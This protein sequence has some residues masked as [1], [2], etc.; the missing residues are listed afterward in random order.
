MISLKLSLVFLNI[1]GLEQRNSYSSISSIPLPFP[2]EL[3]HQDAGEQ[4]AYN[5][6]PPTSPA[7]FQPLRTVP[8][9]QF[10]FPSPCTPV[11]GKTISSI[12]NLYQI[13]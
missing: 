12:K 5:S 2:R 9:Y 7:P 4:G 1:L 8:L 6:Y 11:P 13:L 3:R 10:L